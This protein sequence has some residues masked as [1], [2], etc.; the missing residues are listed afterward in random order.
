MYSIFHVSV[1]PYRVS[2]IVKDY[3]SVTATQEATNLY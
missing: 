1:G 2:D 3:L